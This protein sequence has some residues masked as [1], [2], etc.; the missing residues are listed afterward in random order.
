MQTRADNTS[1]QK[2][3]EEGQQTKGVFYSSSNFSAAAVDNN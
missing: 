3:A 2:N 1:R